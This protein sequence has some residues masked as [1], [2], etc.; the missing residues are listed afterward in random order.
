MRG[1]PGCPARRGADDGATASAARADAAGRPRAGIIAAVRASAFPVAPANSVKRSDMKPAHSAAAL[2][3]ASLIAAT[4]F[5][6]QVVK[7]PVA[8]YGVDI[9]TR[10]MS[11]PG[12]PAGGIAGMMMPGGMGGG[13]TKE[14]YLGLR[15]TQKAAAPEADHDIPPGMNM[16]RALPLL[17]PPPVTGGRSE[18]PDEER[19][20]QKPKARMLVYWGC[21]AA[22]R[23]GQPAVADTEKMSPAQFGEAL[24]GRSP[25]DRSNA[26]RNAQLRWPNE[27]E[28]KAVPAG[29]SIRG[30]QLVHGSATPDI[31]FTIGERQDFLAPF[32]A[33]AKGAFPG[34]FAVSWKLIPNAQ[35]YFLQAIGHRESTG[36]MIVWSASE[37]QDTGW[38][39]MTWLPNDFLRKMIAD[40]VV[41]PP[42][43][44]SCTIPAGI[45][46]GVQGAMVQTIAY[47]EEQNLVQ[48]PR[49]ADPKAAWEQVWTARVRVKSTGM[50]PLGMGDGDET[51]RRGARAPAAAGETQPSVPPKD[52]KPP[53]PVDDA[54]DAVK[55]LKGLF[56]F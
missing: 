51:P 42:D 54:V 23:A 41:L 56:K 2:A 25:P 16:G 1:L 26:L 19:A 43:V 5:A 30:D 40:K 27:R 32:E 34:P 14:L 10:N 35:G 44:T 29:A 18:M 24:R 13:P 6:Q 20:P 47:G 11:I 12:M 39:L 45:F 49:P 21:G 36:E 52:S 31:R 7:G 17:A 15:S 33:S 28:P 50:V 46:E 53:N 37:L 3:A 9:G 48:P 8:Q 55:N 4:A 38:G 22:I